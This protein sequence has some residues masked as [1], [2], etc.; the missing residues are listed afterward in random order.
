MD[1]GT[2][3]NISEAHAMLGHAGDNVTRHTAS[4][5]GWKLIGTKVV[6]EFCAIA[7][8]KQASITKMLSKR[9]E[10]PGERFSLIFHPLR[11]RAKFWLLVLDD[12]TDFGFSFFLKA[13]SE[14]AETV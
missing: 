5:Y 10:I 12:N 1:V 6:C 11:E 13:K 4:F 9:S 8:A 2:N 3:I 7:K 14:R